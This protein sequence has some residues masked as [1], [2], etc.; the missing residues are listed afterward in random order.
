[1]FKSAF[2]NWFL[3]YRGE[4]FNLSNLR[5]LYNDANETIKHGIH[6]TTT[7]SAIRNRD[8]MSVEDLLVIAKPSVRAILT[9]IPAIVQT[10]VPETFRLYKGNSKGVL[11]NP[12]GVC[13]ADH[14]NLFITDNKRCRLFLA[15]L[16]YPVDVTEVSKSLKN[17]NGVTYSGG[18]VYVADTGHGRI[19]YKA[20]VLSVFLEPKKMKVQDI[21]VKLEEIDI[22]VPEASRK[23]DLVEALTKWINNERKKVNYCLSDLNK[24]LLDRD[25]TSPLAVIAAA[26]DM[27]MVTDSDSH[28]VYQVDIANNGACLQGRVN[29]LLR[30]PVNSQPFGLAFDGNNLY[31]GDSGNDGG[32]TKFNMATLQAVMIVKNGSPDCQIVHG[33]DNTSDGKIIFADRGSC[34]VR[35]L[36]QTQTDCAHS[37]IKI[38]AGSGKD[39]SNDGSSNSASFSQ[40][41]AVCTEGKTIYVTDTAV[42]AIRMI[43]PTNSL[44]TFLEMLDVL[45]KI[46]GVHLK[47]MKAEEYTLDEAL[48]SLNGII[49]TCDQWINE[50]QNVIGKKVV[51]QGP[52]GTVSWKSRR[53]THILKESL[54]SLGNFIS[55]VNPAFHNHMKLASTLTLVVENFFSQMRSRNDMPTVIEFAHLFGPTIQESLKQITYTGFK[56]YTSASSYYEVPDAMECTFRELPTIAFPSSVKMSKE[57]QKL[58]RDWRD[59]YG[60]PIRQRTVRN[61]TTKDNVGTLPLFAYTAAP[62][63]P[64]P[65][66]FGEVLHVRPGDEDNQR[67]P[68]H[69]STSSGILFQMDMVVIVKDHIRG[70]SV[71]SPFFLGVVTA[72]VPDDEHSPCFNVK[73]FVP[74]FEDCL[75]F[76][77]YEDVNVHRDSI[78]R[79]V[80]ANDFDQ[81][82]GSVKLSENYYEELINN[83]RNVE[84]LLPEVQESQSDK[85]DEDVG[86]YVESTPMR[87]SSGRTVVR[88]NRL[89][90]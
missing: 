21:R 17:P 12:T 4:R 58:M 45:Y 86:V 6:Q 22:Q 62:P 23:K 25:L 72:D 55:E 82:Q 31:I 79:I 42:G 66:D 18:V 26:N 75:E 47:G 32:I 90:L 71:K 39:S 65:V 37:T 53:S 27:L 57:D 54:S 84:D 1:M 59:S 77:Y 3:Y 52:Q 44:C 67:S 48:S 73:L 16:H 76:K 19:A 78:L 5:V 24:L 88:P 9:K 56:Y 80:D 38:L 34:V 13:I 61:Q 35:E 8:R 41:T 11:E 64:K 51:T 43:T 33:L 83:I 69:E 30:L 70:V 10:I 50:V 14:G 49:S 29:L 81:Q 89:D 20:V 7:L 87:T 68:P 60:K 15:R 63:T 28:G 36:L 40:P 85:D 74:T 46:F 2:A